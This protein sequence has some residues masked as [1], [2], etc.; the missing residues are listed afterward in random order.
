MF[1]L[2]KSEQVNVKKNWETERGAAEVGIS[3]FLQLGGDR[4]PWE[5]N[6]KKGCLARAQSERGKKGA[7]ET[8]KIRLSPRS[9]CFP[10]GK[11]QWKSLRKREREVGNV[12][13]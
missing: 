2:G 12:V 1:D 9:V 5:E 4:E 6:A 11:H 3:R 10:A 7:G 13:F 8:V